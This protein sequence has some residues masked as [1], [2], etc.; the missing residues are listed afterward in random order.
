MLVIGLVRRIA[1]SAPVIAMVRG[2]VVWPSPHFHRSVVSHSVQSLVC[3]AIITMSSMIILARASS[4][5]IW[6]DLTNNQGTYHIIN[7]NQRADE[8]QDKV[9]HYDITDPFEDTGQE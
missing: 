7:L 8:T 3:L 9:N 4:H 1:W 6:I 2:V 5:T